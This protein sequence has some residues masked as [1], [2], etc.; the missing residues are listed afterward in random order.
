MSSKIKVDTIENV[1]GSGNVT[2]ASG[3]ALR[4]ASGDLVVA[5]GNT[6]LT[7]NL[8][9]S[10]TSTL[11]GNA[12]VGGTLGVT[13]ASTFSGSIAKV[14]S[15]LSADVDMHIKTASGNPQMRVESTGA[16]YVTYSLKN[17]ARNYSTQIRTDQSNSYV[18]R[19]ETGGGNRL[20]ISTAGVVTMPSQP[21]FRASRTAGNYTSADTIVWNNVIY[22]Q[23][24]H[25]D[26][27]NGRFTA[28]VAGIYQFN[29]MGSITANPANSGIHRAWINGSAQA[30]MFPIATSSASHISYS[31]SFV[32]NLSANDYVYITAASATWYGTGN[33]HNHFSGF[34]IG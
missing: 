3:H 24:S 26:S 29:V 7:G 16:N 17:S 15:G 5:G 21:A 20:L 22:N 10:G 32:F 25:Y 9:A 11:Q 28:P 30:D 4:V 13:G 19:D 12:T 2:I 34:L 31:S 27:S 33:V 8:N 18:V 23:G 14:S 1:A 6:A